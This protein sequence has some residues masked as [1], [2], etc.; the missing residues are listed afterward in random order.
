MGFGHG[1][2]SPN[3][4]SSF[5]IFQPSDGSTA[6]QGLQNLGFSNVDITPTIVGLFGAPTRSDFDGVSLLTLGSSQ[7][8]PTNLNQALNDA[9]DSFGYNIGTDLALDLDDLRLEC[10]TS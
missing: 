10:P 8:T 6:G 5:V 4:T 3:E 9:V 2:Q 7:V 1:F